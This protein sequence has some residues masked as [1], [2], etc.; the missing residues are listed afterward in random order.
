MYELPEMNNEGV[1]YMIDRQ[2][3]ENKTP[4]KDLK[5]AKANSA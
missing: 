3:I 2:A 5:V 4:L 1:E